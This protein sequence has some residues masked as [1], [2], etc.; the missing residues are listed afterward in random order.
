MKI[1]QHIG[2]ALVFAGLAVLVLILNINHYS[3]TEKSI[4]NTIE[5]S[6]Q[7]DALLAASGKLLNVEYASKFSFARDI[8]KS[9]DQANVNLET[10]NNEPADDNN[11]GIKTDSTDND[12]DSAKSNE[13]DSGKLNA[14]IPPKINQDSSG[15]DK[16]ADTAVEESPTESI[17]TDIV[18]IL[19]K[20]SIEGPLQKNTTAFLW[21]VIGLFS[22]GTILFSLASYLFK[23]PGINNNNVFKK[24]ISSKGIVGVIVGIGLIAFYCILYWY[25]YLLAD[26]IKLVDPLSYSISGY[27]ADDG[28]LYGTI[29][30]FAVL[31]LG[32]KMFLKYRQSTYQKIRTISVT[33]FQ[34]SFAFI[35]P[36]ILRA[37][38]KPPLDLKNIWPLDYS[39][40]WNNNIS[41]LISNGKLGFFMLVWGIV[42]LIIIVP[43]FTYFFGKR[44]YCSWVCGCG[45]LA[46]TAGDPFRQ[47]SSKKLIAWKIER[48]LIYSILVVITLFTAITLINYFSN[49][50]LLGTATETVQTWYGFLIGSVFAGVIGTGLYP[51]M[52]SRVWCRFGCPLSAIFGI[53]QRYKSRFRITT[54]GGQCISCGNCSTYCEMGI[55][56]R[57]YAQKGQNIVRAS[58]VGCGICAEVCP[59]GV[60]KLEN[61]KTSDR[62]N[63]DPILIGN[64]RI[65]VKL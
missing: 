28:F 47:L 57:S 25:P 54:N 43:L 9:I 42:L 21:L 7:A 12:S 34:L 1:L 33:F 13:K 20:N 60:L 35:I 32:I 14:G 45:G 36:E 19:L 44:W 23:P 52:G 31:L 38:K 63:N 59:R 10:E 64:N 8:K 41:E 46:E 4:R 53:I 2:M 61:G 49:G 30:S 48:I 58:C 17:D 56:V 5:D 40:F 51:I 18:T 26:L 6:A 29:Y 24:S 11:K 50:S 39:F 22:T 37:L 3:L 62:I 16:T 27:G 65:E 55:D 15:A